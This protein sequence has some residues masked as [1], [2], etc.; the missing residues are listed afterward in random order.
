MCALANTAQ[1]VWKPAGK[2]EHSSLRKQGPWG[3]EREESQPGDS[4]GMD[5]MW[6]L[7]LVAIQ[8]SIFNSFFFPVLKAKLREN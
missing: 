1:K 7:F 6:T 3:R 8:W 2:S 5:Q 4:R